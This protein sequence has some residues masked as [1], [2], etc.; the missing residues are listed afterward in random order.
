MAIEFPE[1]IVLLSKRWNK[2]KI[3][4]LPPSTINSL[5]II[6]WIPRTIHYDDAISRMKIDAQ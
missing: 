3:N 6:S 5:K 2:N 1:I 4:I